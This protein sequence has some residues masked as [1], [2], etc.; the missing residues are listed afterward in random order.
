MTNRLFIALIIPDPVLDK[1]INIRDEIYSGNHFIKWE[2]K[3]K[4]HVTLKFLGNVNKGLINSLSGELSLIANSQTPIN[5]EFEK[6]GLFYRKKIPRILWAGF[7]YNKNLVNLNFKI[8]SSLI[9]FGFEPEERKFKPHITLLR[10]KGKEDFRR[11]NKFL[12]YRLPDLSFTADQIALVKSELSRD[13]SKYS[14]VKSFKLNK[15]PEENYGN[16]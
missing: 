10:L 12:E 5:L 4:L 6:F 8:N 1:I 16:G 3:E 13:G 15:I 9:K 11:I 2:P 14:I 7:K